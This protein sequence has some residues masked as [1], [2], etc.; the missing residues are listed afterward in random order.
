MRGLGLVPAVA[1]VL[2]GLL[3]GSCGG[4]AFTRTPITEALLPYGKPYG[5]DVRGMRYFGDHVDAE[6]VEPALRL[7]AKKYRAHFPNEVASGR[8]IK[9]DSLA[10]SG[11]GP[12]GAFGAGVLTGWTAR[13]DRPKFQAVTGISTGAIIAPFA[14]LGSQYDPVLKEIYTQYDTDDF[15]RQKVVSGLLGGA[16]LADT[17]GLR[18]LI[19]KYADDGLIADIATEYDEGR[20][21]FIGTTNIDASRPVMWNIGAIAASGHPDRKRLIHDVIQA[22]AA[23]PVAFPPVII[24]VEVDGKL[25][26]EMHVDGG[27]TQQVAL[28][29]PSVSLRRLDAMVGT[30]LD[31]TIHI[32]VNQKTDKPYS[33]V[34]P[35]VMSIAGA[36]VSS[37]INGSGTGDIYK[38]FTIAQ[39]D[40]AKMRV[41]AIPRDFEAPRKEQFDPL[42]MTAL[43]ET[44]VEMGKS[45]EFWNPYPED[46][47]P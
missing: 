27:A 8:P 6:L 40:G 29:T 30:R 3:L 45:G 43:F 21:L 4:P 13:G 15:L 37:L 33:P 10:L 32:I 7:Q 39:R 18:S 24:P 23:I 5:I 44:G 2:A 14:F 36:S 16:S 25:Y 42:Y 31:R 9:T 46:Y 41:V 22:S 11:G 34:K 26:D 20:M 19:E 47:E 12:D 17:S 1:L 38:I 35:R 28:L